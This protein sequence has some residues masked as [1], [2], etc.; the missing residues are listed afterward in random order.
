MQYDQNSAKCRV[1][2]FKEGLL[3]KIAHDLELDVTSFRVDVDGGQVRAEVDATSLRVL[4]ALKDGAP[5]ASALSDDDKRKI[6][7]QIAEDV[8]HA[9]EHPTI[10][11]VS[12]ALSESG[13][14]HTVSGSL[15][16]NGVT[17]PLSATSSVSNGEEVVEVT[18]NQPTWDITPFKAM[19]GTLKVQADVKVRLLLPRS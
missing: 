6:E 19:M 18:L 9:K 5:N 15:T 11:F 4:H 1:F 17:K 10:T 16:L 2:T 8:L 3:S 14:G 12:E 7:G 13:S